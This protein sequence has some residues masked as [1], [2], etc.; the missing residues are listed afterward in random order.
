[1]KKGQTLWM[2]TI[3]AIVTLI[4]VGFIFFT[5]LHLSTVEREENLD[6]VFAGRDSQ[7]VLTT[8]LRSP[9]TFQNTNLNLPDNKT[10]MSDLL[11]K[12]VTEEDQALTQLF[13]LKTREY[14]GQTKYSKYWA[15]TIH[16]YDAQRHTWLPARNENHFTNTDND[17]FDF[18]RVDIGSVTETE[19]LFSRGIRLEGDAQD[20]SKVISRVYQIIP[21]YSSSQKP[22]LI[23]A[24]YTEEMKSI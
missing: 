5:M 3:I 12:Y 17:Y 19:I 21:N 4:I 9:V 24:L 18:G 2:S 16:Y 10:T 7:I 1:M 13:G 22:L 15:I 11:R 20:P 8:F 23:V 6:I 14:F